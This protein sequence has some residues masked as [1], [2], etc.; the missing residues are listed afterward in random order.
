LIALER[1]RLREASLARLG[2]VGAVGSSL[3]LGALAFGLR[4]LEGSPAAAPGALHRAASLALW[5]GALPVA[6]AASA[7]R[8]RSG[9]EQGVAALAGSRGASTELGAM[10]R[11][12]A[13]MLEV[14]IVAGAPLV[15][16]GL[17]TAALGGVA[18]AARSLAA[19]LA[20]AVFAAAC[21]V[22]L[23]GIA[24]ACAEAAHARGRSV[25][26]LILIVP[27]VV[28]DVAGR[29]AWSLPGALRA[30]ATA[31][32]ELAGLG[33]QAASRGAVAEGRR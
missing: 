20:L 25:F 27:M 9:R 17:G 10:A 5:L 2:R 11:A 1:A 4:L 16:L 28:A 19:T 6:L 29:P 21:G 32:L 22:A 15:A 8:A 24:S 31:G 3:V 7:D 18:F 30:V 14:A 33:V 12:A 26:L 13:A 23:G